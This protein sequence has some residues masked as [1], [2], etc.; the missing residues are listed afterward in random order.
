MTKEELIDKLEE[1]KERLDEI[2]SKI[3][4]IPNTELGKLDELLNGKS[5]G[6][7]AYPPLTEIQKQGLESYT[8]D[9]CF[10]LDNLIDDL[11]ESV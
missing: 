5:R 6:T 8:D 9:T 11:K 4:D 7:Y 2:F 10:M 1:I 3:E